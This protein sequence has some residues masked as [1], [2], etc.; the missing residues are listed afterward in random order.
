MRPQWSGIGEK[1]RAAWDSHD[2]GCL[3]ASGDHGLGD[4]WGR[5]DVC[6]GLDTVASAMVVEKGVGVE[7]LEGDGE[8]GR[9][10]MRMRVESTD[11]RQGGGGLPLSDDLIAKVCA[12]LGDWAV[13]RT[14][15]RLFAELAD[16]HVEAI[17]CKPHTPAPIIYR[18]LP[19]MPRLRVLEVPNLRVADDSLLRFIIEHCPTL[20][21]L[22]LSYCTELT[23]ASLPWIML[24]PKVNIKGCWRLLHPSPSL[25]STTVVELQL[26][27]LQQNRGRDGLQKQYDFASPA[28][29]AM[30]DSPEEFC[31]VFH[32][33][34]QPLINCQAFTVREL[35]F[36]LPHSA[37]FLVRTITGGGRSLDYLW[38]LS[39]QHAE[40]GQGCWMTDGICLVEHG[41]L[42][43]IAAVA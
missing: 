4:A 39:R 28:S 27:A 3:L 21:F 43:V 18:L 15:C 17:R 31:S 8:G 24:L 11:Q 19:R 2:G 1:R 37:C 33:R 40:P 14:T 36:D 41:L 13:A 20:S 23:P 30:A 34:F 32:S 29:R 26:L 22:N 12:Y 5:L 7:G 16:R 25:E 6:E 38:L 35:C 42:S 10:A 9:L